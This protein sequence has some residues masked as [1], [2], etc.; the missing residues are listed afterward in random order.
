VLNGSGGERIAQI[1]LINADH[2]QT[3]DLR[4]PEEPAKCQLVTYGNHDERV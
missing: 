2:A 4:I 1:G 3:G